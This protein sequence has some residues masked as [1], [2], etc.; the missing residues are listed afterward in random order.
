MV[1]YEISSTARFTPNGQFGAWLF[2]LGP[3]ASGLGWAW[4]VAAAASSPRYG[5]AGM[6]FA[7]ATL[8]FVGGVAFLLGCIL[9]LVGRSYTHEIRSI[10]SQ[11][12]A[13][14]PAWQ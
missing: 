8:T 4:L 9:M 2:V 1:R 5:A 3:I 10:D 11:A 6:L 14:P 13:E 12:R 7:P